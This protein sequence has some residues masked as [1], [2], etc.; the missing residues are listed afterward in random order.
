MKPGKHLLDPDTGECSENCWTC[1]VKTVSIAPSA[2]VTRSP[3]AARA[4]TTDPQLHR[5]RDAYRRLRQNG[6]QPKHVQGSEHIEKHANESFE[7]STGMI[8]D[9]SHDRI[10][11]AEGF[12]GAPDPASAP[13]VREDA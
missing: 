11:L 13:I 1:R 7:I 5:D 9:D 6:E 12:A 2:L 8:V 4:L 10:R 3:S